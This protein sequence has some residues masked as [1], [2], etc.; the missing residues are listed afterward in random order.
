MSFPCC[1]GDT[2]LE[3]L[4]RST[5][6]EQAAAA[7][8]CGRVRP[9]TLACGLTAATWLLTA[10]GV[11]GQA[12]AWLSPTALAATPDGRVLYIACATANR[13]LVLDLATRQ[14]TGSI[15]V[16]DSPSGLALSA[17]GQTLWVTCAAPNSRLCE[18]DAASTRITASLPAGHTAVSPVLSP[19]G[20]TLYVCNRFNNDV[21][22]FDVPT[23]KELRRIPVRREPVAAAVTRDG[24]HL[25]VANHLPAGRA[26]ADH[27]SAVVS[28][29][30][31]TRGRV[32]DELGL[33]SGSGV[34]N[35]IRVSPDG[36]YAVVTHSLARFQLPTVQADRGWITTNAKTIIDLAR[37]QV[38]NTVL[39]DVM[40][41]GAANPW[42]AAWSADGRTLVV[43]LAGVHEVSITDFPALLEKLARVA[44][45]APAASSAALP[46]V[47]AASRLAA[48]VPNDLT[49]LVGVRERRRLPEGDLG[50]RAVVV[51][52]RRVCVA[53]YF[54]DTLTVME[55]D[56]ARPKT[57]TIPLG[58]KPQMTAVR[59]GELY[60][61]DARI[62]FQGWQ[63]CASCHPGE[64]RMDGLNW[65]LLNDG[66]GNP[67]NNRSLLLSFETPPAMSLGVRETPEA[68]VR[69]GI[70]HIL[71]TVQPPEVA[72][73][74]D[75]YIKS[76]KPVPSPHLE[77]G[78][79]SAAARRGEK[80]FR[81][82][83][84]GCA[85]CHPAPL[86]TDLNSYDV[87]TAGRFDKPTDTFDTPTLV[88]LWRTAP[89]L[90]DGSA[91]TL[92]DVL[93]TANPR[94]RH[95]KTS[96]LTHDQLNDLIEYLLSL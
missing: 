65:D 40:D 58:P 41:R 4:R 33:P 42:G 94:D 14:V 28:V 53:N 68:A 52:G 86:F 23:K 56:G 7:R 77:Q 3:V 10:G 92:R 82:K 84:T 73:S 90:H 70:R 8:S 57:E 83:E 24:R 20:R 80:V 67:K 87:G 44:K 55:L 31:T 30:D 59:R 79:L 2:A 11:A 46:Y 13:V 38:L 61:N 39:L 81:S 88:E 75:A 76:L 78:R 37:M 71:F 91:A 35:D 36:H 12:T 96:R 26:D 72:A 69:A 74:L 47:S 29:I 63:S 19:D 62:C 22:V 50:P 95:G 34:L 9:A 16:P 51:V 49:F 66:V 1:V 93:T 85:R 17:D 45:P 6:S 15:T 64:G 5:W 27:V 21:S 48:D 43:S 60:F 18:V 54:S 32:V 25:L 89:Y